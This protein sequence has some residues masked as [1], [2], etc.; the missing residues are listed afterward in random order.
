MQRVALDEKPVYQGAY[1]ARRG[2]EPVLVVDFVDHIPHLCTVTLD[3][4]G[5]S[6]GRQTYKA[7]GITLLFGD[8][9]IYARAI[10]PIDSLD[11]SQ[12]APYSM[13]VTVTNTFGYT[14]T[15]SVQW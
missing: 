2:N 5:D 11:M 3:V 9:G 15:G 10:I 1:V 14:A 6:S 8:D 13:R 12:Q 7:N 4:S